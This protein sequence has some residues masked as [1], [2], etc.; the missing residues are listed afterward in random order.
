MKD[1]CKTDNKPSM[2]RKIYNNVITGLIILLILGVL[3]SILFK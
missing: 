2:A 3:I 1:C